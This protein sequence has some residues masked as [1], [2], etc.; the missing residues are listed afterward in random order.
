MNLLPEIGK[1]EEEQVE[2][3]VD[4][5]L[6]NYKIFKHKY[7]EE[8]KETFKNIPPHEV[9]DT[10]AITWTI[11]AMRRIAQLMGEDKQVH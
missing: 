8:F 7:G 3:I 11:Y 5:M 2:K 4:G 9:D 6:E 1:E 10:M